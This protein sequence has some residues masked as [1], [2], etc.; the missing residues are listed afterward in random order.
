MLSFI[1]QHYS[2][3]LFSQI[4][5]EFLGPTGGVLPLGP[6]GV[7]VFNTLPFPIIPGFFSNYR[8]SLSNQGID[9]N[10]ACNH[11]SQS[12]VVISGIPGDTNNLVLQYNGTCDGPGQVDILD[13]SQPFTVLNSNNTLT[14]W[15]CKSTSSEADSPSYSI[16]L[17]GIGSG[18][19]EI[20]GNITCN[21]S[22][23]QSAIIPVTFHSLQG[24]FNV[25]AADPFSP[26]TTI[27][28][29]ITDHSIIALGGL[30]QEG[31]GQA[32]NLLAESV[33]TFEEKFPN[34]PVYDQDR[35]LQLN[36]AMIQGIMEYLVRHSIRS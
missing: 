27:F 36:E 10:V 20:I 9:L 34:S 22:Q 5:A 35:Y 29:N 26:T 31:Q 30:V 1:S 33:L 25:S 17:R 8:Y 32:G 18:Y 3:S 2:E 7:F 15:A 6:N 4:N 19:E 16:Y 12:P 24:Y 21:I 14:F 13:P 28:S 11:A 23:I